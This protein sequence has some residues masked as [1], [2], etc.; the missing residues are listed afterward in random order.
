M[1]PE[2]TRDEI[3]IR[4]RDDKKVVAQRQQRGSR[5]QNSDGLPG[6]PAM[7][8]PTLSTDNITEVLLKIIEFTQSRQKILIQNI[9]T[10]YNDGFA[11]KDLPVDEFSKLMGQALAEHACS[12]R[13]IL[14]DGPNVK[15]GANGCFEAAAI[16]DQNA[17]SLFEC[18]R[19]EYI[20]CQIDKMLENSLNLKIAAG[21]L[22]QKQT[23]D[24]SQ[25]RLFN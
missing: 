12:G 25:E 7:N 18:N 24:G 21:L 1:M 9:N 19:D 22:R 17:K 20:R 14:R 4:C 2:V 13:L 15:F 5:K 11:P 3:K 8:L 6:R 10:M 16:I 23:N